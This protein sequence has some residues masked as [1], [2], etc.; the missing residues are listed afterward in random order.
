M[1]RYS[2]R[3]TNFLLVFSFNYFF[4]SPFF[5]VFSIFLRRASPSHHTQFD[6]FIP[7]THTILVCSCTLFRPPCYHFCSF[8]FLGKRKFPKRIPGPFHPQLPFH[9]HCFSVTSPIR[10]CVILYK[11]SPKNPVSSS[12][13]I[14]CI[15]LFFSFLCYPQNPMHLPSQNLPIP[16]QPACIFQNCCSYIFRTQNYFFLFAHTV[17]LIINQ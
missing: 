16:Q 1:E 15:Y 7:S 13:K 3:L 6:S 2:R 8:E 17:E 11:K 12:K 9:L 10:L 4:L 5:L 14:S